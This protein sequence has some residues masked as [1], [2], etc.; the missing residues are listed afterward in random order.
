METHQTQAGVDKQPRPV[1]RQGYISVRLTDIEAVGATIL[2]IARG[3]YKVMFSTKRHEFFSVGSHVRFRNLLS[4]YGWR[5]E[6]VDSADSGR[7]L[8]ICEKPEKIYGR[9]RSMEAAPTI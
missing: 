7:M 1:E 5:I 3:P 4:E 8:V 9:R 2:R 6:R